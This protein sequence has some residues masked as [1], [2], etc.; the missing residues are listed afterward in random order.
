MPKATHGHANYHY[1]P[2]TGTLLSAGTAPVGENRSSGSDSAGSTPTFS[3][4]A[5][6][7][8]STRVAPSPGS[9]RQGIGRVLAGFGCMHMGAQWELKLVKNHGMSVRV[10]SH[11]NSRLEYEPAVTRCGC[12]AS[13]DLCRPTCMMSMRRALQRAVPFACFQARPD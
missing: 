2:R 12:T 13:Q 8:T 6:N 9:S 5:V 11:A 3:W 10:K 7:F 1:G 4:N